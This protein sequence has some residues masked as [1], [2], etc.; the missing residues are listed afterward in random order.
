MF[1]NFQSVLKT[2]TGKLLIAVIL[3]VGL[4]TL[5]RRS[6]EGKGCHQFK[7]PNPEEVK[8]TTYSHGGF[9]Y[10]FTPVTKP[11]TTKAPVPR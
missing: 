9:C 8:R 1:R 2:R 10:K 11:C 6:C 7:A 3:G 5:F 4:A